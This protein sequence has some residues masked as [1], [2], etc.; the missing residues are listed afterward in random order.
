MD[1]AFYS[2]ANWGFDEA[3]S[4]GSDDSVSYN[5][6]SCESDSSAEKKRREELKPKKASA[7]GKKRKKDMK[8]KEKKRKKRRREGGSSAAARAAAF[9]RLL[10]S[11]ECT[12][13]E[14]AKQLERVTR[15]AARSGGSS[16]A[17]GDAQ[18]AAAVLCATF[19]FAA[20]A[21]D[22]G[23]V[24]LLLQRGGVAVDCCGG[25]DGSGL[26]ALHAACLLG[27]GPLATLLVQ[28]GADRGAAAASGECADD[29]GLNEL[30]AGHAREVA[31]H[32]AAARALEREQRQAREL[33]REVSCATACNGAPLRL[34]QPP[35]SVPPE[36]ISTSPVVFSA[37]PSCF[38]S[39]PQIICVY[40]GLSLHA[41]PSHAAF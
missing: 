39:N 12:Q 9:E 28:H 5:G 34:N 20:A 4:S 21:G 18:A 3:H 37:S 25:V 26:T 11:G 22:L 40:W 17:A 24:Q 6:Q 27:D 10:R 31:A 16:G 8:K 32:E 29:L 2:A 1:D 15:A 13:A 41:S 35:R 30:L 19:H 36:S 14:L 7:R 23:A 38:L 33:A